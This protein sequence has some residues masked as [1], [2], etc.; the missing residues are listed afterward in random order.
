ME[1]SNLYQDLYEIDD[2]RLIVWY[3]LTEIRVAHLHS[4][5]YMIHV[6]KRML[7]CR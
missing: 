1:H 7:F 6:G 3:L 2:D 4:I 5:K